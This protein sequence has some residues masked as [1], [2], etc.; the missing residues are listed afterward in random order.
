M[1]TAR[2]NCEDRQQ[3]FEVIDSFASGA[4]AADEK[5]LDPP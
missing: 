1:N 4:D 2:F 5:R 3:H